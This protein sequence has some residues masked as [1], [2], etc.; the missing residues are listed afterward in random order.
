MSTD[1]SH[2]KYTAVQKVH[3]QHTSYSIAQPFSNVRNERHL[4]AHQCHKLII[5][6]LLNSP[7]TSD[8][9]ILSKI[10]P[11]PPQQSAYSCHNFQH[12]VHLLLHQ[13]P[14]HFLSLSSSRSR[15]S[16]A[17]CAD[18]HCFLY[19]SLFFGPTAVPA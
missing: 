14:V 19:S 8:T 2:T 9:A 7:T 11:A 17:S 4:S 6:V 12:H 13:F 1:K 3:A 10:H 18:M 5:S 16:S 15:F